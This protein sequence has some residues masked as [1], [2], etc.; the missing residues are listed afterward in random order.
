MQAPRQGRQEMH[1]HDHQTH[2]ELL[3]AG[4]EQTHFKLRL[5]GL[6]KGKYTA[7]VTAQNANGKSG[8]VK[9]K[10]TSRPRL[11]LKG[12]QA[13]VRPAASRG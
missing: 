7:A 4:R 1:D 12:T 3:G 8:T 6:A 9:R 11:T 2:P 5:R 13:G 10:F